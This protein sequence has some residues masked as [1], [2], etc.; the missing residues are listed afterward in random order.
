M[1]QIV[2]TA[3]GDIDNSVHLD[4]SPDLTLGAD[5]LLIAV[6][7]AP[8]NPADFL[9]ANGWYGIQPPLPAK[10]GA[11][12][13]GRVVEA[14]SDAHKDLVGRRVIILPTYKQGT[15]A[16]RL[17]VAANG[18]VPVP[19][20]VDPL[21]L[22]MLAI[23]PATAYLLLTK[24]VDLK[25]GDWIGQNLGNSA[26]AQYVNALA[27]H[28][29]VKTV[30][31][32]RR[33]E[34]AKHVNADVVLVDGENL[35]DRIADA[36]GGAKFR[37]VLDGTGDATLAALA[38]SLGYGG[39]AVSYS[40]VT[41][42]SPTLPFP[43]QVYQDQTLRGFFLINWILNAPREEIAKV[44]AELIP[45][46]TSGVINAAVEATYPLDQF[47]E[48]FDHARKPERTGKVLFTF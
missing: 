38:G 20:D 18:V 43:A 9:L 44:Y 36:L 5:D 14:G 25:P 22:A 10:L 45:L 1:S 37:L 17:V 11:E 48:A 34:A 6:E 39:T 21:Q 15:W 27:K 46:I 4:P 42:Q 23:N 30:S 2:L 35:G 28:F 32:V 24:F 12:G 16:D 41:N 47:R 29:G 13:V 8:V 3:L 31:V 19:E 7:A 26:V 40:S 33:E